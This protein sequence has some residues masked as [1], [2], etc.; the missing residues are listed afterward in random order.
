MTFSRSSVTATGMSMTA[1]DQSLDRLVTWRRALLGTTTSS[2]WAVRSLVT[3]RVSSSTVPVMPAGWPGHRQPDQVTEGELVLGEEEEPGQ[4]VADHLLG[5]EAEADADDGGRR[6][7]GGEGDPQP[8]EG[9]DAGDE[10]GQGHH[11][12]L[13]R[14]ADGTGPLE[15]SRRPRCPTRSAGGSG[16]RS[17]GAGGPR[18]SGRSGPTGP[19]PAAA[20]RRG[21]GGS[22]ARGGRCPETTIDR[23]G[24]PPGGGDPSQPASARSP[25][26]SAAGGR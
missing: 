19:R 3:R 11:R 12:P 5:A 20:R 13:D 21:A 22:G 10:G 18:T 8:V 9:E 16:R 4:Q 15:R 2:P 17:T 14:L 24:R 7:Q 25:A 1:R 6:H 23:S 26:E